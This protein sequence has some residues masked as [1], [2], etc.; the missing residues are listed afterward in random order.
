MI[1]CGSSLRQNFVFQIVGGDQFE[2]GIAEQKRILSVVES[3]R[4]F[5]KVGHQMLRRDP[6]PRSHNP[7]LKQR[8]GRFNGIRVNVAANVPALPVLD[9]LVLTLMP[10]APS[11]ALF[12]KGG[13]ATPAYCKI[14][15]PWITAMIRASSCCSR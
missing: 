10:G 11:F 5:V 3:P 8:E 1:S 4:H 14:L 12:A 7:A 6:M 9:C 13:L 15:L 2:H